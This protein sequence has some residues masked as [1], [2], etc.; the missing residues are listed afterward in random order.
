MIA[1]PGAVDA[2]L[3]DFAEE[4]RLS[5]RKKSPSAG[6]PDPVA[7]VRPVAIPAQQPDR[8]IHA[9]LYIPARADE[10]RLPAILFAH[11]GGF[12]AGSIDT[13]D[14]LARAVA[15]RVHAIV[16]SVDYR[17]APEH[18]FPAGLE[19]VHAAW[20]WLAEHAADIGG[21]PVRIAL[22]GDSAGGN[23]VTAAAI[24]ARDRSGP[25]CRALWLMYPALDNKMD[26]PS[27][28]E[29]GETNF[30]TRALN[31]K[32][33]AAYVS[34]NIDANAPLLAPSSA[35]LD[36]LPPTLLQ[37]GE[38]DPLRDEGVAFVQALRKAGVDATVKVYNKQK[39]GFIQF[40]K[41]TE[42]HRDG[43]L[44]LD[45]AAAFLRAKLDAHALNAGACR[46]S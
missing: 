8:I 13:H 37:V 30:P 10:N 39:H 14:V 35:R 25:D 38:C 17:L 3:V 33:I 12:V 32:M 44:A 1:H 5:Y 26:T 19:D 45:E 42:H 43:A 9:R 4:M 20:E 31:S 15:N 36:G 6:S 29:F 16:L 23:L 28:K 40:F 21:D 22:C 7:E 2:G 24:L 34:R 27:W 11:G 41:D 46:R 18:Q